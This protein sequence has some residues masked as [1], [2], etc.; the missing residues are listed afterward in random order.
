MRSWVRQW[1]RVAFVVWGLAIVLCL[2][3]EVLVPLLWR[4]LKPWL[5][6]VTG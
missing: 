5:H 1:P 2:L 3:F 6:A 4:L